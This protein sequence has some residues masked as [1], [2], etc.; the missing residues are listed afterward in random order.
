QDLYSFMGRANA[1]GRITCSSSK[2]ALSTS[3][4]DRKWFSTLKAGTEE[5]SATTIGP[6]GAP[7]LVVARAIRK[8]GAFDGAAIVTIP[9]AWFAKALVEDM[10]GSP[11]AVAI[12]D[13]QASLV[14]AA[15]H[16]ISVN[17]AVTKAKAALESRDGVSVGEG[18]LARVVDTGVSDYRFVS[19][20]PQ[21]REAEITLRAALIVLAPVLVSALSIMAIWLALDRWLLRWFFRL[22]DAA[23]EFAL[24]CY[25]PPP[26]D[27]A[28]REIASLA[29]AFEAAVV[30]SRTREADLKGALKSNMSLTRELHHRVKNNLQ[31]ISSL[32]S[33]QQ[34]RVEEPVVRNALGEARARMAPVALAYRFINPPEDLIAIDMEAYLSELTRQLHVALNGD[35]RGVKLTMKADSDQMA[36]DDATNLGLIVSEAFV[37]GYRRA[38]GMSGAAATLTS[39]RSADGGHTVTVGVLGSAE[40]HDPE[41]GLDRELVQELARQLHADVKFEPSGLIVLSLPPNAADR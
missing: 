7:N 4:A 39:T 38:A 2:R 3:V 1:D 14:A 10:G 25:A 28:P 23:D 36:V 37:S 6:S 32:I 12:F 20:A 18:L 31:V 26:M 8:D 33:R 29:S 41:C 17:D 22:R 35:A 30:Q 11:G 21:G 5:T 24:G 27:G 9:R 19:V 15:A 13:R 40:Q 34:R 16:T